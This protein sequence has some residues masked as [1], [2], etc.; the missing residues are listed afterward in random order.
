L[1]ISAPERSFLC[2]QRP[3]HHSHGLDDVP[4]QRAALVIIAAVGDPRVKAQ[5]GLRVSGRIAISAPLARN[6]SPMPVGY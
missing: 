3:P 4:F 1:I 5:A 2:G 6:S